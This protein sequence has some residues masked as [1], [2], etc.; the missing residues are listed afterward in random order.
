MIRG[1]VRGAQSS[2]GFCF[3]LFF[4]KK[5][6]G[7]YS[8]CWRTESSGMSPHWQNIT[9]R[10]ILVR[11]RSDIKITNLR[12]R[13]ENPLFCRSIFLDFKNYD[14]CNILKCFLYFSSCVEPLLYTWFFYFRRNSR[15]PRGLRI[16]PIRI[17][18][19]KF[20]T[21]PNYKNIS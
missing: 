7:A 3:F 4:E 12:Q 18:T 10:R 20:F 5:E 11:R 13:E 6:T 17:F 1:K 9:Q 2:M 16:S 14:S 21:I 8:S 15:L 19:T